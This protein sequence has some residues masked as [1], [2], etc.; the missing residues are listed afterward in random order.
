M[1]INPPSAYLM[2]KD[3]VQLQEGDVVIQ[4]SAN[5]V[6]G[7]ALIQIASFMKLK[8]INIVRDRPDLTELADFLKS[9]GATEVVTEEAAQGYQFKS[10]IEKLGKPKLALNGVG[11]KSSLSL[12]RTLGEGGLMVTYGGMSRQPVTVTTVSTHETQG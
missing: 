8:T 1:M 12:L 10:I 4:N 7:Q 6:V 3:F 9:L 11:G 5:S 2:L